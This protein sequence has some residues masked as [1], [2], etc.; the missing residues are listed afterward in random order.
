MKNTALQGKP[1]AGNLHVRFDQGEV[2]PTTSRRGSLLYKKIIIF[3]VASMSLA[4]V[5]KICEKCHGT[6][7]VKNFCACRH[8]NGAGSV[9]P[10]RLGKYS[11]VTRWMVTS[12][13]IGG[14]KV[15][16]WE[17]DKETKFYSN[18][19]CPACKSSAKRGR[20]REREVCSDCKG[21]GAVEPYTK[22]DVDRFNR[23]LRIFAKDYS[24]EIKT[25]EKDY[26]RDLAV[27]SETETHKE[28][29]RLEKDY[30][31]KSVKCRDGLAQC[32]AADIEAMKADKSEYYSIVAEYI[33]LMQFNYDGKISMKYN[34]STYE[35][36]QKKSA[37]K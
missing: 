10:G 13:Y 31:D 34:L 8:C 17:S 37:D 9:A 19:P 16:E 6:G 1:Y 11:S 28:L 26:N 3:L 24:A 36:D 5:A 30:I 7:F 18:I 27:K 25:L 12:S 20:I 32:E 29:V 14:V 21:I 15:G 35:A 2:A 4:A 22:L 23:N 33:H